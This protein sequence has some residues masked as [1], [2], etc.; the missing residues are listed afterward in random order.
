MRASRRCALSL[1]A[2]ASGAALASTMEEADALLK[3]Q[4]F[5]EAAAAYAEVTAREPGNAAAWFRQARAS[6]AAG[7]AAEALEALRAWIATGNG[8][9]SAAMAVPELESLRGDPAFLSLIGPLK[10]CTAAEYRQFDFWQGDW[11]VRTSATA[12]TGPASHN[13]ISI[14]NDGCSLLEQYE[15]PTAGFTGKSLSFYDAARKTWHQSWI[16]N[17]GQPLYLEGGLRDGSMVMT[18]AFLSC[19]PDPQDFQRVTWTPLPEGRVRQLWESTA[20]GGK[21]WATIFEGYYTPR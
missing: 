19:A 5:A 6:A 12:T 2:F 20:D 14:I 8:S 21:T 11:D 16:D 1:V 17:Q 13:V 18:T 3:A 10:P 9:Y 4:K 15:A 7:D